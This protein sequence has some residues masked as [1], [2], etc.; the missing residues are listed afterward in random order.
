MC[1][2][3][4]EI[5]TRN[6]ICVVEVEASSVYAESSSSNLPVGS[7][8]FREFDQIIIIACGRCD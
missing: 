4:N 3:T 7:N 2:A 5:K 6:F 1:G 8:F